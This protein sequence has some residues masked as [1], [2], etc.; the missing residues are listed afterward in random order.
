M[1]DDLVLLLDRRGLHASLEGRAIRVDRPG[2]PLRR[3]P[4]GALGLVVVH[5]AASVTCDV[6]RALAARKIPAVL[7]PGRGHADE[8]WLGAGISGGVALRCRQH[9]AAIQQQACV[10]LARRILE[11]KLRAQMRLVDAIGSSLQAQAPAPE[12]LA[13]AQA[14]IERARHELAAAQRTET[15]RGI[16]GAAA[17][18]WYRALAAIL[19]EHWGFHGRN[20]RPPRDP[21]NALLSLGYTLAS[22]EVRRTVAEAGLDPSVGFLHDIVPGRESLVLDLVEPLRPGVDAA[23]MSL[24]ESTVTPRDFTTSDSEGCRLRKP[25]R[26]MFY[27]A[28]A[29]RLRAWPA[30]V[31]ASAGADD[32]TTTLRGECLTIIR[33]IRHALAAAVDDD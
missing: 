12:A 8:A 31:D 4:L 5:G 16:E 9:R 10:A 18:A 22:G 17:A 14:Q 27:Q 13:T 11:L 26:G 20:R 7:M 3:I 30:F 25:A 15:L 23:V 32:A 6:W 28:W 29:T 2:E 24:L 21:V 19:P 1:S 33:Q